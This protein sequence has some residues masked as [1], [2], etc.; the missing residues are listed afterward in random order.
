MDRDGLLGYSP[1]VDSSFPNKEI[2]RKDPHANSMN[3]NVLHAGS[4]TKSFGAVA[5]PAPCVQQQHC[6]ISVQNGPRNEMNHVVINNTN[7]QY[8]SNVQ[9]EGPSQSRQGFI[10]V[11]ARTSDSQNVT[12]KSNA[13]VTNRS[14][15]AC[16]S[17]P[18]PNFVEKPTNVSPEFDILDFNPGLLKGKH[19]FE[20]MLHT[21]KI[22]KIVENGEILT[23]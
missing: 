9:Y 1:F 13:F 22:L 2:L 15:V 3:S 11:N 19:D 20:A 17:Q 10:E 16:A 12:L 7:T 6:N 23:Q 18:T 8:S 4:N 21:G 14:H 5:V